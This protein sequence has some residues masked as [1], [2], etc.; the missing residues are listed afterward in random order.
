VQAQET[1]QQMNDRVF[2]ALVVWREARGESRDNQIAV[3]HVIKTRASKPGWWGKDIMGV[4]FQPWQFSSVT[5]PK[6]RQL[7][8]WPKSSDPSW[9]TACDV[10]CGVLDGTYENP[11]PLADSYYD[12]SIPAPAWAEKAT[13]IGQNG[14]LRFYRVGVK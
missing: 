1:N 13:F 4:L 5:D 2:T 14:R 12:I 6:D 9:R 7:T 10:A 3:A 11:M 8:T